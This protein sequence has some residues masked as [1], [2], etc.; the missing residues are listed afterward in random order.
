MLDA[1]VLA[2]F[3]L[4]LF[5]RSLNNEVVVFCVCVV[6]NAEKGDNFSQLAQL[7]SQIVFLFGRG[8]A[9]NASL[10]KIF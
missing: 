6:K 1:L 10:L 7:C 3:F 8:W 9:Q 5:V 4:V 2:S